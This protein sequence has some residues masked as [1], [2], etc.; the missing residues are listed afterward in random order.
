[1][2]L[3]EFSHPRNASYVRAPGAEPGEEYGSCP[4]LPR[5]TLGVAGGADAAVELQRFPLHF[6]AQR[7]SN[8]GGNLPS[9]S[10]RLIGPPTVY[11]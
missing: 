3:A 1:M 11:S 2:H 7:R 4:E 8:G 6:E 5:E 9:G 10:D